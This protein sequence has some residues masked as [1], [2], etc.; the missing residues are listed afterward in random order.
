MFIQH[1]GSVLT[2]GI[3]SRRVGPVAEPQC[4]DNTGLAIQHTFFP[5]GLL[6]RPSVMNM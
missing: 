2:G 6:E 1:V 5:V 3:R 4:A